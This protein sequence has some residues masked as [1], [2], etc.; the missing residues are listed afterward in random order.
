MRSLALLGSYAALTS[1]L[2]SG[3]APAEPGG[4]LAGLGSREYGVVGPV[5]RS[6]PA[7]A[8]FGGHV[9]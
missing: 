2:L 7:P 4:V 9:K 8:R 3:G 6:V 1:I 5:L